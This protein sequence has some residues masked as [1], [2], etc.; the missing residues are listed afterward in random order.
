MVLRYVFFHFVELYNCGENFFN[1]A[2]PI[3]LLIFCRQLEDI[4]FKNMNRN[5]PTV[6]YE[7]N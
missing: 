4:F 1:R 7:V 6:L 3:N 2:T 5:V